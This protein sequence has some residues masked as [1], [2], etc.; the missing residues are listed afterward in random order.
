MMGLLGG[1]RY[2]PMGFEEEVPE[3]EGEEG[4]EG[5]SL[6]RQTDRRQSSGGADT[7]NR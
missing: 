7:I 3:E 1:T 6:I 5:D 2:Q 4:R